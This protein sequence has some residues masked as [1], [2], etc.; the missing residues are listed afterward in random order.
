MIRL[1]PLAPQHAPSLLAGQDDLLAQEI[2]G[3][4]WERQPLHAF[5]ER[6][7]RWRPDGPLREFAALFGD[8]TGDSGDCPQ[9]PH[10]E[11][12][13]G[14]G[15]A[16]LGAG[17]ERGQGALTY[18]VLA[19]HRRQGHGHAIAAALVE[20]ARAVPRVRELVLRI[21]PQNRASQAIARALGASP[22][23]QVESHPARP[24]HPVGR[25]VLDLSPEQ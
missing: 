25:W 10:D 9:A 6:T 7:A 2:I 1:E 23:G 5:L 18:W 11:L 4:R 21:A 24:S 14:G 17:L 22:T 13:G 19:A 20:Q 8:A 3:R 15:L 12:V 16:L